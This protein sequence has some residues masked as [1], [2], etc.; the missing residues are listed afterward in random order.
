MIPDCHHLA[1]RFRCRSPCR[2]SP[3]AFSA[4][5]SPRASG[6]STPDSKPMSVAAPNKKRKGSCF[7]CSKRKNGSF[8]SE[9]VRRMFKLRSSLVRNS[10]PFDKSKSL[11]SLRKLPFDCSK[12]TRPPSLPHQ[13]GYPFV[14]FLG[15]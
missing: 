15:V 8:G 4:L 5:C 7:D 2:A 3:R 1:L 10:T 14:I 11:Y 6:T 12:S 9:I 13:S